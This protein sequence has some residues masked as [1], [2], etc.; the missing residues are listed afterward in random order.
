VT[1]C[2]SNPRAKAGTLVLATQPAH[3]GNPVNV[4]REAALGTVDPRAVYRHSGM[5]PQSRTLWSVVKQYEIGI[6]QC[7]RQ[8]GTCGY[9]QPRDNRA[10][11]PLPL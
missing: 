4:T 7:C 11:G 3:R 10:R 2:L 5:L 6:R 8:G 9:K 1:S